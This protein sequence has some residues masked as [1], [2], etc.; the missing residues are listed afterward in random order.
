MRFC[1]DCFPNGYV[2]GRPIRMAPHPGPRCA[3]HWRTELAR[4]KLAQH[5]RHVEG[6]YQITQ[7]EY[8]AIYE[9]QGG[10]CYVC[11]KATGKTKALAVDHDH[12][13]TAGHDPK[14]GCRL[15]IRALLCSRCNRMI[16]F[17]DVDALQRAIEVLLNHP[18]QAILAGKED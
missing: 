2:P 13:C 1:K 5:G 14:V 9:A 15:C 12:K 16:G 10:V 7:Q 3:T 6:T 11:R 8:V 4:R 17:L 18:A